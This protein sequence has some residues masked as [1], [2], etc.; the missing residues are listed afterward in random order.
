MHILLP[1]GYVRPAPR[2]ND[3]AWTA[4]LPLVPPPRGPAPDG[5]DDDGDPNERPGGPGRERRGSFEPCCPRGDRMTLIAAGKGHLTCL[6][7]AIYNQFPIHTDACNAAAAGNHV[8]CLDLLKE[9]NA[10]WSAD[11]THAAAVN[12]SFEALYYLIE[13]YCTYNDDLLICAAAG[14]SRNCV[15]Y[16]VEERGLE[17]SV[18]VFGA[19][20]E[21]AHLDCVTYLIDTGCPVHGYTFRK[22]NEWY[23]C[24]SYHT[25]PDVDERFLNCIL[26]AADHAWNSFIECPNLVEYILDNSNVLRLC[27]QHVT[28]L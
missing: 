8:G 23:L 12:G 22:E 20:F 17:M 6:D 11:T 27:K 2:G 19:A 13:N 7:Y 14:G 28:N 5:G 16:L 26:W 18:S 15:R 9:N 3:V 24:R 1:T 10:V 21:R 25:G 4:D